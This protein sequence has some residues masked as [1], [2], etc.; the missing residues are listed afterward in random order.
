MTTGLVHPG[1]MNLLWRDRDRAELPI[2]FGGNHARSFGIAGQ[3][4]G[5]HG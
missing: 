1:A 5:V 3:A 4:V 2:A